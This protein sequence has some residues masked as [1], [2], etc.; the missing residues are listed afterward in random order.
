MSLASGLWRRSPSVIP[1]LMM[2]ERRTGEGA[3]RERG[4]GWNGKDG[5]EYVEGDD[6]EEEEEEEDDDDEEEEE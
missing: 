3:R 5:I 4:G 6:E 1:A 2:E